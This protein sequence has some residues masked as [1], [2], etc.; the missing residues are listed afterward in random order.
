M[1][2]KSVA[3]NLLH[4]VITFFSNDNEAIDP[5]YLSIFLLESF[6]FCLFFYYYFPRV[7]SSLCR[8]ISLSNYIEGVNKQRD[9]RSIHSIV[10]DMD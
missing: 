4:I 10:V 8:F 6:F 5:F 9:D 3:L 1:N 2:K 7:H